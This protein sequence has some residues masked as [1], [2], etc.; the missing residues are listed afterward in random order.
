MKKETPPNVSFC[1]YQWKSR[2]IDYFLTIRDTVKNGETRDVGAVS[3]ED[4]ISSRVAALGRHEGGEGQ[5]ARCGEKAGAQLELHCVLV[6]DVIGEAE[7]L[8]L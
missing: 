3:V 5:S 6:G 1:F 4:R 8:E 7:K 2:R